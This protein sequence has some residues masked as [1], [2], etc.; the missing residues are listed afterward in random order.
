MTARVARH[1]QALP[2]QPS[3]SVVQGWGHRS[4]TWARPPTVRELDAVSGEHQVVLISGDGHNGW[5][6]SAALRAL[7]V[8]PRNTALD[9]N[10]WFAVFARLQS[11]PG[12][13]ALAQSG[14]HAAVRRASALGVVG[15]VDM[16]L[17]ANYLDW[18]ARYDAGV[19]EL[20]V[21][22]ATYPDRL[23]DVL[24]AGLATGT[25]YSSGGELLTMGPLKVISDGSLTPEPP[26]ASSRMAMPASST[27]P[28]ESRT[29]RS[30][31]SS[32]SSRRRVAAGS[33]S[34]P[35]P[36][37]TR[38]C[39]RSWT[40]SSVRGPPV[41][42]NMSRWSRTWTSAGWPGSGSGPACS[43]LICGTTAT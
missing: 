8:P 40:P 21:R 42:S 38:P 31:T 11:L 29:T 32:D 27:T 26:T 3:S 9:E 15:I 5:L 20:K 6:N 34:P 25:P 35:T 43:R 19:R 28:G 14:F 36:S 30:R 13:A 22:G 37:A 4:A 17:G 41:R 24:A 1:I 23:P 7:G 2:P 39:L 12:A 10:D 18:P 16:E 33:R